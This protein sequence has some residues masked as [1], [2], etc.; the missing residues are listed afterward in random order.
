MQDINKF[1]RRENVRKVKIYKPK[2]H[3]KKETKRERVSRIN[4]NL[5]LTKALCNK[6]LK[7]SADTHTIEILYVLEDFLI[8][9]EKDS[10]LD[11][12]ILEIIESYHETGNLNYELWTLEKKS[13]IKER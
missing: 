13:H 3:I 4:K 11:N 12:L 2:K 6:L 7:V 1:L 10:E 9:V 8:V 5:K